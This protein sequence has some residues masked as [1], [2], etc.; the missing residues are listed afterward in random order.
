MEADRGQSHHGLTN[1]GLYFSKRLLGKRLDKAYTH[2][3]QTCNT[4]FVSKRLSGNQLGTG[5]L[6]HDQTCNILLTSKRLFGNLVDIWDQTFS[7]FHASTF[8]MFHAS[9]YTY[10]RE[11]HAGLE[12]DA[13]CQELQSSFSL[14]HSEHA[15]YAT[16]AFQHDQ[17]D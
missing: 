12:T 5:L 16:F 13:A 11:C 6:H 14:V 1:T 9:T 4:L 10:F 3:V 17:T 8:S 7:M 15:Y 2:H